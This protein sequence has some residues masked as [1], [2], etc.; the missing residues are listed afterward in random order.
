MLTTPPS[1][2]IG[3]PSSCQH[4]LSLTES[5]LSWS[6]MRANITKCVAV[7]ITTG[8]A[9]NPNLTLSGQ[10]IHYLGDATFRFLGAP[11]AI[12]STSDETREHLVTKLLA[13]LPRDD[14]TSITRQQK[15]KLFKLSI[16]PRLTWDLSISD[17][18][19]SSL[20]NTLQPI[21]TR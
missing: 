10:P 1:S 14:N 6:G 17:L 19:V 20:Q 4:L 3:P 13:M 15:I 5:C 2:E 12:H 8:R 11:V 16:Y 21:A 9:Y 18:P 7:A